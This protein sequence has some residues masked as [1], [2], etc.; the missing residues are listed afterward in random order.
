VMANHPSH[1]HSVQAGADIAMVSN[2]AFVGELQPLIHAHRVEG[3]SSAVVPINDLYDEFNFGERSPSAIRQFLQ[4]AT[5]N[6]KTLPKYLL[7]NGR[8]SLDPR[9]YLGFGHLDFVPTKIVPTSSLMTATDDWFSDFNDSGVPAIATGRLPVSSVDEAKTVIGKIVVYEGQS[10][11]GA[12]T[13]RAMMVADRNDTENFTQDAQTVQA[14]LPSTLQVTDVFMSKVGSAAPNE[15]V[16]GINSGQVLVDYLGHGSEDQW[17]G[18][19]IFDSKTVAS[20]TNGSQLPVF[21]IMDCL[22]GFFQDVYDTPLGVTLMLAPNGGGIAVLASSG[23]NQAPPQTTL[24]TLVVQGAFS[25][26]QRTLGDAIVQAKAQ[27]SDPD[28]RKTYVLFGDPAMRIK[29]QASNS[30][31]Q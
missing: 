2:E 6:W 20:L 24:D 12:W 19:N 31:A 29:T 9:N 3:R 30:P 23:L 21:L 27:I 7:L 28:V 1:W 8:A 15:I 18:S 10:T 26:A 11:N 5:K 25:S 13:G 4:A 17:S 22:N 14:Q 16:S